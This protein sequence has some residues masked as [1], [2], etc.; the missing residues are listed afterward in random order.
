VLAGE[1]PRN[2]SGDMGK[3]TNRCE[4]T[5]LMVCIRHVGLR[6]NTHVE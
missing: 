5:C 1:A 2:G 4:L 3:C 6:G